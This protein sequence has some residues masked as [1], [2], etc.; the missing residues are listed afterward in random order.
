VTSPRL[1][2]EPWTG[3]GGHC[4]QCGE[5][6]LANPE[7]WT[8]LGHGWPHQVSDHAGRIRTAQ[9]RILAHRDSNRPENG[10]PF[11]QKTDL[12]APGRPRWTGA[13][14]H[15]VVLLAWAGECPS[16]QE[17]C[18]GDDV[19]NH[20]CRRNLRYDWP[21]GN[22][23][24]KARQAA[25]HLKEAQTRRS[26]HARRSRATQLANTP[27]AARAYLL[28][29]LADGQPKPIKTVEQE[30][31]ARGIGLETLKF[32]RRDLGCTWLISLPVTGNETH[33]SHAQSPITERHRR[34]ELGR[35]PATSAGAHRHFTRLRRVLP[36][37][38]AGYSG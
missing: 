31:Q 23:A 32:A 7:Q 30:A 33:D 15:R 6:L 37:R 1:A 13:P 22:A 21:H 14:V 35:E 9:G 19:P 18:H 3:A 28:G 8:D 17:S 34:S 20:N 38:R 10:P 12:S 24:D 16:G 25:Y 11:Y 2:A 26:Q 27:A 4:P 36:R 29:T 5:D